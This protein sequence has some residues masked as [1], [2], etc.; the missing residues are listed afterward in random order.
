[1]RFFIVCRP[2]E[3]S[4]VTEIEGIHAVVLLK[5]YVEPLHRVLRNEATILLAEQGVNFSLALADPV[6]V[7]EMGAM[8]Y[9]CPATLLSNPWLRHELLGYRL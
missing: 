2:P 5:C 3:L 8:R 6:H 4:R 1:M 7:L 9:S